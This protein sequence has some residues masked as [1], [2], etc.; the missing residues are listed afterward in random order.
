MMF[1]FCGTYDVIRQSSAAR[2]NL[3]AERDCSSGAKER[4]AR[5]FIP[6][7]RLRRKSA[8]SVESDQTLEDSVNCGHALGRQIG[9]ACG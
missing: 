7:V 2:R 8:L 6:P 5:I 1:S 4:A 9:T 3:S